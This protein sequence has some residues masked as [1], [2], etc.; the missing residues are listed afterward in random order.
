MSV[1]LLFFIYSV[2]IKYAIMN[3]KIDIDFF[4]HYSIKTFYKAKIYA[5]KLNAHF[6]NVITYLNTT[7]TF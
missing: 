2:D 4:T 1:V 7:L 5:L 6:C 3:H